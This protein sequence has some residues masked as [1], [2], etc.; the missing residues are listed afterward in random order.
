MGAMWKVAGPCYRGQV[1]TPLERRIAK[2]AVSLLARERRDD[3]SSNEGHVRD[4]WQRA[5]AMVENG[6]E[7]RGLLLQ[8]HWIAE[9]E[10]PRQGRYVVGDWR[11]RGWRHHGRRG[12]IHADGTIAK[13]GTERNR[14]DAEKGLI[15]TE[16]KIQDKQMGETGSP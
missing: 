5:A 13:N 14:I 1:G 4:A 7:I 6:E 10:A 16:K 15:S 12:Y 8:Q 2:V 11:G 9:E 3:L